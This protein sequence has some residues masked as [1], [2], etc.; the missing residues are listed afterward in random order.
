[1][2]LAIL[3]GTQAVLN[4]AQQWFREGGFAIGFFNR[5]DYPPV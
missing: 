2:R 1:L 3:V 4:D 5:G